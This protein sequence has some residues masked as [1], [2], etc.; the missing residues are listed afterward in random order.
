MTAS[1]TRRAR[2]G[3]AVAVVLISLLT[4][5]CG[6]DPTASPETPAALPQ[7]SPASFPTAKVTRSSRT[8]FFQLPSANIGCHMQPAWVRCDI[9]AQT[10]ALPPKPPTC[11]G[12]YGK[13]LRLDRG[14]K[15][16][17][18]CAGDSLLPAPETVDYDTTVIVERMR[19]VVQESGVTCHDADSGYGFVL[20]RQ[21]YRFLAPS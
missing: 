11:Q 2:S 21:E 8:A 6:A 14:K 12:L 1:R 4:A 3:G 5:A 16:E 17:I 10:Y 19:C 13:S 15:A 20:S 9:Q 18:L 7:G